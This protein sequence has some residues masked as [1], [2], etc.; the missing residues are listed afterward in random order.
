MK[1]KLGKNSGAQAHPTPQASFFRQPGLLRTASGAWPG[2]EPSAFSASF[3]LLLPKQQG[4]R[5][6]P[7]PIGPWPFPFLPSP[8]KFTNHLALLGRH[9]PPRP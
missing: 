2:N 3:Q 8:P 7:L 9:R 1:L 4:A 5:R 6:C